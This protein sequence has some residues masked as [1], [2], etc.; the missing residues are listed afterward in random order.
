MAGKTRPY[1]PPH[2]WLYLIFNDHNS[3]LRGL[4][5]LFQGDVRDIYG[6]KENASKGRE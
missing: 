6:P 3:L 1:I 5:S 4:L 2:S